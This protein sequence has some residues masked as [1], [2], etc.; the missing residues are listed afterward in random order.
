MAGVE[1]AKAGGYRLDASVLPRESLGYHIHITLSGSLRLTVGSP[2]IPSKHGN[3]RVNSSILQQC[4]F[5]KGF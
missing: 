4:N 3:R 2:H 1:P 5:G